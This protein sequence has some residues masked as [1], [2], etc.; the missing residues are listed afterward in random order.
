MRKKILIAEIS[1]A[2][3]NIA[4]SILHQN[5]YDVIA[6]ASADKAKELIITTEPNLIIIGA[7]MKDQAGSYLYDLI[8]ESER[9][10]SIPLL[11]IADPTGRELSY[12]DEVILPRP[13]KT[14]DFL[15]RVRLFIGAGAQHKEDGKIA[16]VDPFS[17]GAVD[18]EFLDAA[19]GIDS[20][21]V[22]SSEVMDKT[23]I[24]EKA[25]RQSK[26][27]KA[28][29]FSLGHAEEAENGPDDDTS[30]KVESLL[31]REDG[32]EQ[33]IPEKE[34]LPDLTASSKIEISSDQYGIN[35]PAKPA[36]PPERD[37]S[38]DYDW[39]INEMQKET[40]DVKFPAD[41]NDSGPLKIET[42]N[43]S[44]GMEQIKP[45]MR[46][47]TE[48]PKPEIKSGGVDKFISEFKE[49]MEKL[50]PAESQSES[51]KST[52]DRKIKEQRKDQQSET[53]QADNL[54]LI[55][56]ETFSKRLAE[57]IAQMLVEKIDRKEMNRL[58]SECLP[59]VLIDKNK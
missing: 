19:L 8:E 46:K 49:E 26:T 10:A 36:P 31:I 55:D 13:F 21:D 11:I 53:K 20:I 12:P 2:V 58:I 30:S 59:Q 41:P 5:G 6:S 14:D 3:R 40:K 44:E 27:K 1:D 57:K 56:V 25:R 7:D 52:D 23:T 35:E 15:E 18:D 48:A 47:E 22:E 4:E 34:E 50:S 51:R 28:T 39:F 54:D 32:S 38:H 33:K 24:T 29:E 9:T 45:P 16:E 42:T 37:K 43:P 17:T